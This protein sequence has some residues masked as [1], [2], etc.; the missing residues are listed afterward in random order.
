[1]NTTAE[2]IL[3]GA[4]NRRAEWRLLL[5]HA[6]LSLIGGNAA[7]ALADATSVVDQTRGIG[8]AAM[9]RNADFIRAGALEALGDLDAAIALLEELTSVSELEPRW[10]K[11]HIALVRCHR[12]QGALTRA[13]AVGEGAL[14][15]IE[16]IGLGDLTEAIQLRVTIAGAYKELGEVDHAMRLCQRAIFD[17]ERVESPVAKASAYWNASL[18]ASRKGAHDAALESARLA[19]ATFELADDIRNLGRLRTQ[20]ADLHLRTTPPDAATAKEELA[21][22]ARE[23]DWSSATPIDRAEHQLVLGLAQVTLGEYES[24]QQHLQN[25][26]RLV[27]EGAPLLC[28]RA[29]TLEGQLACHRG[30]PQE[31]GQHYQAAIDW[32]VAAGADRAAPRVWFELA[33]QLESLGDKDGSLDAYRNGVAASGLAIQAPSSLAVER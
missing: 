13:V 26:K 27:G 18:V 31:A 1:M 25:A 23:L 7:R 8:D 28:A 10:V 17:A 22:A 19:L 11:A 16:E 30:A 5:D 32:L 12:E 6:E 14:A 4:A 24:A 9:T 20:V 33:A 3:L 15:R 29:A 21:K 2:A